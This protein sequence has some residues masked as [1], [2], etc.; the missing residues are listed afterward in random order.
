MSAPGIVSILADQHRADAMGFLGTAPV[1]TPNLDR[2]AGDGVS[3]DTAWCVSPVCQPSRAA[4]LTERYPHELG[5]TQNAQADLDPGWPTMPR[6]LAQVGYTTASIGKT[7]YLTSRASTPDSMSDPDPIA[8]FGFDSVVDETDLH[9]HLQ[10]G[11]RTPYMEHLRA[12]GLLDIYLQAVLAVRPF[13]PGHWDAA[14]NPLPSGFTQS[15]FLTDR[16]ID[17]LDGRGP[18]EPFYLQLHYIQPHSPLMA[19]QEWT[20]F[21]ADI[22]V[23]LPERR[24][25]S[26]SGRWGQHLRSLRRRSRSPQLTDA[27]LTS[28][29]H[30]YYALISEIDAGIGRVLDALDRAGRLDNTWIIYSADHGE[31]LG[32]HQ[33]MA[34]QTFYRSSVQVPAII[35]PPVKLPTSGTRSQAP[36]MSLDLTA[37]ILDIAAAEPIPDGRGTTLVPILHGKEATEREFLFSEIGLD[38]GGDTLFGAVRYDATRITIEAGTGVVCE[39]F[40]LATDPA[41][42]ENLAGTARGDAIVAEIGQLFDQVPGWRDP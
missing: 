26:A 35:R 27:Y 18:D 37:T 2:L 23:P 8:A 1:H 6:A 10:T 39:A 3:F 29:I 30:A 20:R 13:G 32:D 22:D 14:V 9:I 28:A 11:M 19:T 42:V 25:A 12:A 7:H 4:L 15:E 17:W 21:Y 41:E 38:G 16:A 36:I 24:L 31:M 40:D 33:L 34:K 5:V